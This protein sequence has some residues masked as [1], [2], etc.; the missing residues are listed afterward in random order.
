M[1]LPASTRA[2]GALLTGLV[3]VTVTGV[4]AWAAWGRGQE[5]SVAATVEAFFEARQAQD[6]GRLADLLTEDTWSQGQQ[7]GPDEFRHECAAVVE[8]HRPGLVEVEVLE[9]DGT[10]AVVNVAVDGVERRSGSQGQQG[11]QGRIGVQ[12]TDGEVGDYELGQLRREGGEWK[13]VGD[14][15]L[16]RIGRSPEETL[17]GFVDAFDDGDCEHLV[18][19]LSEGIRSDGGRHDPDGYVD[20][21]AQAVE[22]RQ[23]LPDHLAAAGVPG[24]IE[25]SAEQD[26]RGRATAV[27][28]VPLLGGTL[29]EDLTLVREGL[30]WRLDSLPEAVQQ[31]ELATSLALDAAPP[32]FQLE[33]LRGITGA[34]PGFGPF[35]DFTEGSDVA[36]TRAAAGF[37]RGSVVLFRVAD[38]GDIDSRELALA[39][40]EFTSED[41]A[42]GYADLL[43][44]RIGQQADTGS[45][46]P[47]PSV[48]DVR[49]AVVR[50]A[51]SEDDCR[52]ASAA[53]G[54]AVDGRFLA[55]AEAT[56]HG[57]PSVGELTSQVEEVLH[58]QLDRF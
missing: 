46:A 32:D 21:C 42:R 43:A 2:R 7:L 40:F 48:E 51:S 49:S 54:L 39:L 45:P 14:D 5:R 25:V 58:A 41:G 19:Y 55:I 22:A 1:R 47:V 44:D 26:G 57:D 24:A 8:D 6:C 15:R 33:S 4:G 36:E 12:T 28:A 37:E 31:V 50:C 11:Q 16:F 18:N 30:E 17:R 52:H 9:E 10:A 20:Q 35:D 29:T 27:W 3:A 56:N 13:V 38:A 23:P 53:V 34:T